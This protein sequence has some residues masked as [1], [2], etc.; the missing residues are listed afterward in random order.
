MPAAVL[1]LP[2]VLL[3]KMALAVTSA[4]ITALGMLTRLFALLAPAKT[5][6]VLVATPATPLNALIAMPASSLILPELALPA[7]KDAMSAMT[8]TPAH[9]A[10]PLST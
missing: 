2:A 9:L 6:I 1:A 4:P 8:A 10:T 7:A 3:A 5:P